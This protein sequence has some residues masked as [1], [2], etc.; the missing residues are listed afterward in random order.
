MKFNKLRFN[1]RLELHFVHNFLVL[2]GRHQN[3]FGHLSTVILVN[4]ALLFCRCHA[5]CHAMDTLVQPVKGVDQG[6]RRVSCSRS[7]S[8]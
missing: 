1:K 8:Q 3:D 5:R 4:R 7:D 2:H 6:L